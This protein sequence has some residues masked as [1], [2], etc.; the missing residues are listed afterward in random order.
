MK[1]PRQ[2][3]DEIRLIGVIGNKKELLLFFAEIQAETI[4]EIIEIV[5]N[6]ETVVAIGYPGIEKL[7]IKRGALLRQLSELM[8]GKSE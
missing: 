1:T 3:T 8:K 6:A 5:K 2:L 7:A 4:H